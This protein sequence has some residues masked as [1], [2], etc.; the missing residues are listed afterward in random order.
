REDPEVP[1]VI[2]LQGG[3]VVRVYGVFVQEDARAQHHAGLVIIIGNHVQQLLFVLG[4]PSRG[5]AINEEGLVHL[6]TIDGDGRV[7][8]WI[9]GKTTAVFEFVFVVRGLVVIP[10][11][12][13]TIIGGQNTAGFLHIRKAGGGGR[14]AS[15]GR[16]I[17]SHGRRILRQLTH[18]IR[19]KVAV[20]HHHARRLRYLQADGVRAGSNRNVEN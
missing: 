20:N 16:R 14:G 13:E 18:R 12:A 7:L 9:S 17:N 5:A 1:V 15:H 3:V 2:N 11:A 4:R 10:D 19:Y 6:F 8:V